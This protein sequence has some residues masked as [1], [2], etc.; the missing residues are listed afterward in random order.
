[1]PLSLQALGVP[2]VTPDIAQSGTEQ[3]FTAAMALLVKVQVG[4]ASKVATM[5]LRLPVA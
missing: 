5:V 3:L 4:V 1:M 2:T